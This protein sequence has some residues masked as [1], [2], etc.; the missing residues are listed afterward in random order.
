M[1]VLGEL[2]CVK[3]YV[4]TSPFVGGISETIRVCTVGYGV[5]GLERAVETA[6][7]ADIGL[8]VLVSECVHRASVTSGLLAR[9][10]PTV[11]ETFCDVHT[12]LSVSTMALRSR[13]AAAIGT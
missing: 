1:P 11:F 13:A 8:G 10:F 3:R 2:G 5:I 12:D 4:G 6:P 7:V 9:K